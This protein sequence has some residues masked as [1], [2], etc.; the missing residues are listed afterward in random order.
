MSE[1]VNKQYNPQ[2]GQNLYKILHFL[3]I[4]LVQYYKCSQEMWYRNVE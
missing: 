2:L 1:S 4:A 3:D